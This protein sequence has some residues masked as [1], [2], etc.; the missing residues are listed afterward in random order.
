MGF[1]VSK[2]ESDLVTTRSLR[3]IGFRM[4]QYQWVELIG[5]FDMIHHCRS[6]S[7]R[8]DAWEVVDILCRANSSVYARGAAQLAGK[9]GTYE[10]GQA[11]LNLKAYGVAFAVLW[12]FVAV[13]VTLL[14]LW[15]AGGLPF[16]VL[17]QI[18]FGLLIPSYPGL[19]LNV[20]ICLVDGFFAGVIFAWIYNKIAATKGRS[21]T[22]DTL[23]K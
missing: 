17:D 2:D 6:S 9:R 16:D 8:N 20:A 15:G 10:R 7:W 19:A 18:Y 4:Q 21:M 5:T 1:T 23:A 22:G 11:M 13:W 14:Q 12:V 3:G